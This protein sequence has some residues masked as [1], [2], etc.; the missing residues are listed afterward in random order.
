[1]NFT[2]PRITVESAAVTATLRLTT[3]LQYEA[4]ELPIMVDGALYTE[5]DRLLAPLQPEPRIGPSHQYLYPDDA[6]GSR[7][8][9][10]AHLAFWAPLSARHLDVIE[11]LR[12]KNRKGDA[13]LKAK[14]SV[15]FQKLKV[16]LVDLGQTVR[17]VEASPPT[18]K[19]AKR[20]V[21]A[22]DFLSRETGPKHTGPTVLSTR[23]HVVEQDVFSQTLSATIPGSDWL[24][25]FSPALGRGRFLVVEVPDTSIE[26]VP[27]ALQERFAR[28]VKAVADAR[29]KLYAGEWSEV[30]EEL[31]VLYEVLRS[32][33]ELDALL[34]SEY[35]DNAAS[36]FSSGIRGFFDFASKFLHSIARDGKS[37]NPVQAA[38]KEDAQLLYGLAASTLNMIARKW[39]RRPPMP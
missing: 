30:C 37:L 39:A 5:T 6:N 8:D 11:E 22:I 21:H 36:A 19:Q 28:A 31:R 35:G 20:N 12:E 25:D 16:E 13:I 29:T 3:V 14:L 2:E 33:P 23:S 15:Q 27:A 17:H 38:N 9:Q 34:M 1:M 18:S 32:W 4:R 10:R 7:L 24:N 26:V